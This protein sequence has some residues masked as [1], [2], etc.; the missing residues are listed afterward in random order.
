MNKLLA[1]VMVVLT[2]SATGSAVAQEKISLR[3]SI[4]LA[5]KNSQVV[6]VANENVTGSEYR[7]KENKSLYFP[8]ISVGG[9]YTRMS[10][11]SEM[12]FAFLGQTYRFK[13]GLPNNYDF[14]ASA[15]QQ[16]FNWGRTGKAIEVSRAGLDLAR[17][18]VALTN[19]LVAYQVVPLYFGVI[20]FREAIK[21]V[22]DNI[23]LFEKKLEIMTERYKAGL[24][25]T[26]D[27]STIEV[28]I[29]VLRA[30]KIDFENNI[31]KLSLTFNSLAAREPEAAFNPDGGLDLEEAGWNKDALLRE[32]EALR[33]EFAQLQHQ[34]GLSQAG[35]DLARTANKPTVAF[36]FSYEFRNGYMPNMDTIRGN[37]S[38]LLSV[39]YPLFDGFRA[40]AQ[41]AQAE[42]ALR[43][44]Q[45]RRADLQ[46]S[47]A[48]DIE[49]ALAD[50]QSTEQ[51]LKIEKLKIKQAEDALRI[52]DERYQRGLL[53][54]TDFVESQNAVGSAKLNQLQLVYNHILGTYNLYRAAGKKIYE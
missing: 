34:E 27:L 19:Q 42:S 21:V 44:V 4:G 37:W 11:F 30:Q 2:I 31:H 51:K 6:Q 29:S 41:V 5:L 3:E 25:S 39:S 33:V 20:F 46:R 16:V 52:A 53:S 54:A 10:L 22:D 32:A 40:N 50:L 23:K 26:F 8:Q 1:N 28:Q 49:T 24:V 43:T 12:E 48:L 14:R 7:I 36:S 38:A 47:V 13:F 45:T 35:I 18:G 17:D 9:S 15:V